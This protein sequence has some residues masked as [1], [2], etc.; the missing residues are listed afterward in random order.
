MAVSRHQK[1]ASLD[2]YFRPET[3]EIFDRLQAHYTQPK[4]ARTLTPGYDADDLRTVF[5]E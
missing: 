5:G 1:V 3:E 4:P 2:P